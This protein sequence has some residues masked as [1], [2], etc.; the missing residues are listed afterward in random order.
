MTG[1]LFTTTGEGEERGRGR[2]TH[3]I[4]L[5]EGE[6]EGHTCNIQL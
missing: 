6:G 4:Q 5:C 1:S 3:A 2:V